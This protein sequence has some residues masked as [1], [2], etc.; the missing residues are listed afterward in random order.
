MR[1]RTGENK[2]GE[3]VQERDRAGEMEGMGSGGGCGWGGVALS[4]E[5]L[6]FCSLSSHGSGKFQWSCSKRE[7]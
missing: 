4:V 2:G 1:R 7:R 6:P 3:R 5:R